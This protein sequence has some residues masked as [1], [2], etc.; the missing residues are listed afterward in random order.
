MEIDE[1]L[2]VDGRVVCEAHLR[3]AALQRDGL[4]FRQ[5]EVPLRRELR[6]LSTIAAQTVTETSASSSRSTQHV[7]HLSAQINVQFHYIK[8]E[9]ITNFIIVNLTALHCTLSSLLLQ[10]CY[11]MSNFFYLSSKLNLFF[12]F[13]LTVIKIVPFLSKFEPY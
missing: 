8:H 10:Y 9:R 1:L 5:R 12:T 3:A 4:Q 7:Q 11:I 6:S 13:K 2:E